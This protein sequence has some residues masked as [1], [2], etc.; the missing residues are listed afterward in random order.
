MWIIDP[1]VTCPSPHPKAPTC[2]SALEVLRAREHT[3]TPYPFVV[4]TFKLAIES[5]KEFGGV[6]S[7]LYKWNNH[8]K[9][10]IA[11]E[12]HLAFPLNT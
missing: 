5:I 2:P 7:K 9:C 11:Y 12:T 8:L 6:S 3:P 10:I 1:L 4:F